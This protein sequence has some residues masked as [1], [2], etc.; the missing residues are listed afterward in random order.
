M[1][2]NNGKVTA[3]VSCDD[4]HDAMGE[5]SYDLGTLFTSAKINMW[6]KFKPYRINQ[7]GDITDTQRKYIN[8]GLILPT[9][10]NSKAELIAGLR[11][12]GGSWGYDRP[13]DTDFQ[14]LTDFDGYNHN[15]IPPFGTIESQDLLLT[16]GPVIPCEPP[17]SGVGV[18]NLGD[19]GKMGVELSQ[20]YFGV[21]LDDGTRQWIATSAITFADGDAW[22]VDFSGSIGLTTGEYTAIPFI[23]DTRWI[24]GQKDPYSFR[25]CGIG[26]RGVTIR[27]ISEQE[28]YTITI[29]AVW[30]A[31]HTMVNCHTKI[32]NG[33]NTARS[34]QKTTL[35]AAKSNTGT[36]AF[37]LR[38]YG[39]VVVASGDTWEHTINASLSDVYQYLGINYIGIGKVTWQP[40]TEPTIIK[41]DQ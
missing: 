32:Y 18:I 41:P 17:P 12:N 29:K 38:D 22:Q 27:L 7:P 4:V 28:R 36:D 14:R 31:T 24:A 19:F 5:D 16:D 39:T 13:T 26:S 40:I 1:P 20:W 6:A 10:Y 25:A 37:T 15:A 34:F 11:S 21:I 35:R 3:P 9:I 8:F 23:C 2:A 33:S 30:N